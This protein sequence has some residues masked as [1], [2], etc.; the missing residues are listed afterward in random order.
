[1]S[2]DAE[3]DARYAAAPDGMFS[4][5]V[6]G[7]FAVE[8]AAMQPR[9]ALDVGCGEG[10]DAIWLARAGW[11]V[12]ALD[13]STVA[14]E[15]GSAAAE[16]AG[17]SVRWV[18]ADFAAK[19]LG[20]FDL[21]TAHYPALKHTPDRAVLRALVA[22][23]ASGGTLLYVGHAPLDREFALARG[24]D[25]NDY[26][27]PSDVEAFLDDDWDIEVAEERPRPGG[28]PHGSPFTHDNILR[29]RRLR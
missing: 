10:A 18:A 4:G 12:T 26:V 25:P 13:I 1:M 2:T 14:V 6:N 27:R 8:V 11:Y 29:A 5:N 21:V 20:Q 22:A 3:W 9:T 16:A 15:R 24:F 7:T 17:V 19:D 28:A 23:V